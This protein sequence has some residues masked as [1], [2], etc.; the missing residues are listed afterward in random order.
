[1]ASQCLNKR[2]MVMQDN[3]E[4]EMDNEMD[5]DSMSSLE[6]VDDGE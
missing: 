4:I 1:M 2:V 6:D 3:G 5:Y